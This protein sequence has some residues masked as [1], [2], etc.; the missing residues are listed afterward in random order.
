[1]KDIGVIGAGAWGTALAVACN[2]AGCNVTL[3]TRNEMVAQSIERRHVNAIYLPEVFVDPAIRVTT[4]L[5]EAAANE[6][7]LLVVPAQYVRANVIALSN[8]VDFSVPLVLCSKGI[9]RGSLAL[10]SE[11]VGD[12]LPDNPVAVLSGPNFASELGRGLPTATTV[13]CTNTQLGEQIAFAIGSST[14]RP[15]FNNDVI[16]T[17]V[18]GAVKNVIAIACGIC[19]A[20]EL[21]ENALAALITRGVEEVRRLAIAKG[22]KEET[23]LGL[24]G[25]GDMILTCTS[26]QSRNTKIGYALGKGETLEDLM[27]HQHSVAE[28]VFSTEAVLELANILNVSMPIVEAIHR[29]LSGEFSVKEAIH[30][31]MERPIVAEIHE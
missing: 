12:V 24:S 25:I 31:L 15:Y 18:A 22:G 27:S 1:M 13:A 29:L 20:Q 17:Q 11:V 5:S 21:G 2:R 26:L 28:G 4:D 23:L 14:F 19:K 7:L 6:M 9:E 30:S 8:Q 3:W 10:M 16:G